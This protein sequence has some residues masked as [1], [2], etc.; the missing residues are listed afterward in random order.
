MKRFLIASLSTLVLAAAAPAYSGVMSVVNPKISQNIVEVTPFN[1]VEHGY[2]GYFKKQGIPSGSA[3]IIAIKTGKIKA[4]DLV[5]SGIA[6][7]R[8]TSETLNN[9]SYLHSV[10][11]QLKNFTRVN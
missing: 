11:T 7:G 9:S 4:E 10:E 3:F 6:R 8:L 5:K 2:Q 1:L